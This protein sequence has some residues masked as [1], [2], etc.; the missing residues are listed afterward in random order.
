MPQ[1]LSPRNYPPSFPINRLAA[2]CGALGGCPLAARIR[3][4]L[5]RRPIRTLAHRN[6]II[7]H[8]VGLRKQVHEE[9]TKDAR[10][11][12]VCG[13]MGGV[14]VALRACEGCGGGRGGGCAKDAIVRA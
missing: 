3:V 2:A 11:R 6:G 12:G 10:G 4:G 5:A 14:Y 13:G 8:M 1:L 7:A 9:P